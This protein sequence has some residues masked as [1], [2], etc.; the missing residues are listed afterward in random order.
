[1]LTFLHAGKKKKEETY[2]LHNFQFLLQFQ[3]QTPSAGAMKQKGAD[4]S[5]L[6]Y[7]ACLCDITETDRDHTDPFCRT[8]GIVDVECFR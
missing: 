8:E 4:H 6:V 7:L 5:G 3:L 2:R 1:M